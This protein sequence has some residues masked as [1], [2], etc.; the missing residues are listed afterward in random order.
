M[1]G[2][3][4]FFARPIAAPIHYIHDAE[5]HAL[6]P[7]LPIITGYFQGFHYFGGG[8]LQL[9]TIAATN[10]L[11]VIKSDHRI[12]IEYT[13]TAFEQAIANGQENFRLQIILTP[14]TPP[15]KCENLI[16]RSLAYILAK[17]IA[18]LSSLELI[19]YPGSSEI[20]DD[21]LPVFRG[22]DR[23]R[24]TPSLFLIHKLAEFFA[25]CGVTRLTLNNVFFTDDLAH[26]LCTTAI[27]LTHLSIDNAQFTNA[28]SVPVWNSL[29]LRELYLKEIFVTGDAAE[30]FFQTLF[31]HQT[32][33]SLTLNGI[34]FSDLLAISL[35]TI[36]PHINI[37]NLIFT[38]N[39]ISD[40]NMARLSLALSSC[41]SLRQLALDYG[42]ISDNGFALLIF[43]LANTR[44]LMTLNLEAF[45]DLEQDLLPLSMRKI[46]VL[47][48]LLPA[49][50]LQILNLKYAS[51]ND[52]GAAILAAALETNESLEILNLEGNDISDVG[53]QTL[54]NALS[55][56]RSL[57]RLILDDNPISEECSQQL[58]IS[59]RARPCPSF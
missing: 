10:N 57:Q 32:L 41:H 11:I 47:V 49:A 3:I 59:L 7:E 2:R 37:Q 42:R 24:Y 45:G 1:P 54:L 22:Q 52:A 14:T 51:I 17:N 21:G 13:C 27:H 33:Q 6:Y 18:S 44:S 9:I 46:E 36:L 55:K 8:V 12:P 50:N 28:A 25:R 43:H 58:S 19:F 34:D 30:L 23:P 38:S 16:A 39:S 56:N 4:Y 31:H 53:A 26:L 20:V 15:E 5:L 48:T 35:A 40:S 29:S